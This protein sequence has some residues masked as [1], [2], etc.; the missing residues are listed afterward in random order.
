MIG[1]LSHLKFELIFCTNIFCQIRIV[2]PNPCKCLLFLLFERYMLK[3]NL[4]VC[5]KI[6]AWPGRVVRASSRHN[7]LMPALFFQNQ[8]QK[9]C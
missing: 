5:W 7:Q 8:R 1:I 6:R 2:L 3:D 9:V 4:R